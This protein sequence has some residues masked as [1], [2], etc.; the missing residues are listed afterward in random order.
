MKKIS[1]VLLT[2]N[3]EANID[4]CLGTLRWVD[5]IVVVDT[6]STDGTLAKVRQYTDRVATGDISKGFAHNRNLGNR[7]ARNRWILKIDPDEVI[8]EPLR[9][10]IEGVMEGP[11]EVDGYYMATRAFFGGKWIKGCGWYPMYQ[12]RLFDKTKA[13]WEGLIHE[14]L[15]L[16]G[17]TAYLQNDVLHYS[18]RDIEHYFAKF[19]L[20]TS[21]EARR[22]LAEGRRVRPRDFPSLF[23]L[24]PAGFFLKSFLLQKGWRDGFYGF[25][26]SLY[27]AFYVLVKYMKL[28]ELQK[29]QASD[30][31]SRQKTEDRTAEGSPPGG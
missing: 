2:K 5:E 8:P 23:L 13:E 17:R 28:Y 22:L 19:N 14:R 15:V 24:R 30:P 31:L 1:A 12:V 6:G 20:Y 9:R 18:Y 16:R 29:G 25:A 21:F 11:S 3:E 27:S 4:R 10:E 7:L 26:V